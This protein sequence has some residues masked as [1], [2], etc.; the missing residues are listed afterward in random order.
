MEPNRIKL[1]PGVSIV[2]PNSENPLTP[3]QRR[4]LRAL[5]KAS[6]NLGDV[7]ER[8]IER[9]Q[10]NVLEYVLNQ[11][12]DCEPV[13]M[14]INGDMAIKK[15][16]RRLRQLPQLEYRY[17]LVGEILARGE[18]AFAACINGV[19]MFEHYTREWMFEAVTEGQVVDSLGEVY[20]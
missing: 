7:W 10:R 19:P 16:W 3:A 5:H 8:L 12:V 14:A 17:F 2:N 4:E 15:T 13:E 6:L 9:Q 20:G 1:C 18:G 11:L